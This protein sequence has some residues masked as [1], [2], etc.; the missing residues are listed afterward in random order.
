[1]VLDAPLE[2]RPAVIGRGDSLVLMLLFCVF[3]YINVLDYIDPG[4]KDPLLMN[5]EGYP[6]IAGQKA[7]G[8]SWL[9]TIGGCA[10]LFFGGKWAVDGAVGVAG[11]LGISTAII[12][13]FV[14]AVGTSLP[15]LVTSV[16]AAI[17][18]ESDLAVG[19]VIGSNLF[20]SLIVL[21][22]SGVIARTPVPDGGITDLVVS[23]CLVA[24][25]FPIFFLRD[26]RLGRVSGVAL[27][28][29]YAGY[30]IF[31]VSGGAD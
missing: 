2:G 30:A 19:N 18:N 28:L 4:R 12:G 29:A 24:M 27:L 21:P 13:L 8:Y 25:L 14:V 26:G 16:I 22:V 17:R 11:Y 9:L 1:M 10:M 15:E 31:R 6:L 3:I 5:V 7:S 23:W 20:N